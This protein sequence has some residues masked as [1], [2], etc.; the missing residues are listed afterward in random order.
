[1]TAW[2]KFENCEEMA[3]R[4]IAAPHRTSYSSSF[5][6]LPKDHM[7]SKLITRNVSLSS[8][9]VFA[10]LIEREDGGPMRGASDVSQKKAVGRYASLK[11][12]RGQFWESRN[13]LH[14]FYGA[15][16]STEV[17]KYRAQPHTLEMAI[18]GK[19]RRYTPDR[20]DH[21]TGA[22]VEI[23]E[24]KD[25][26]KPE[27]D[28]DYQTK[29]QLARI[30]YAGQGWSFR[31]T[32]RDEIEAEPKFEAAKCIQSFRRTVITPH[33]EDMVLDFLTERSRAPLAEVRLLW[34]NPMLGFAKLCALM[35][36]RT[37]NIAFAYGLFDDTPVSLVR[38]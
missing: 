24:I 34:T 2:S 5:N 9:D 15:E 1:M 22:R 13:E 31:I 14:A 18:D 35:V 12:G 36:K 28:P 3:R 7:V 30:V 32:T 4:V 6:G 16:V 17:I 19:V 11:N 21:L 29:I 23:V 33:D 10:R 38:A 8:G 26:Y 25:T 27:K 20:L 37:I